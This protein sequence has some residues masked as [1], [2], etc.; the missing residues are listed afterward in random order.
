MNHRC[1]WTWNPGTWPYIKRCENT[2][3]EGKACCIAHQEDWDSFM[4]KDQT[5]ADSAA[6]S[7]EI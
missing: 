4:E 5:R 1:E 6:I 2:A 3:I 7:E